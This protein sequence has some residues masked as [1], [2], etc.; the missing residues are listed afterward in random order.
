MGVMA[1]VLVDPPAVAQA[2]DEVRQHEPGRV[3]G[4]LRAEDL[5][6]ARVM[7]DE[8]H[9]G[10]QHREDRSHQ[11]LPPRFADREEGAGRRD[12]HGGRHC[13][14]DRVVTA[15]PPEQTGLLDLP[16][17]PRVVAARTLRRGG[18]AVDFHGCGLTQGGASALL[19]EKGI[20]R[21]PARVTVPARQMVGGAAGLSGEPTIPPPSRG[22]TPVDRGLTSA[23]ISAT[24]TAI[25]A[26]TFG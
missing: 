6:M 13:H 22:R 18:L 23:D 3:V 5:P 25:T 4:P 10:E 20:A 2:D 7:P 21:A 19:L 24:N 12:G 1:V 11:E 15:P 14:P 9:L 26:Q 16:G 17:E 8:S